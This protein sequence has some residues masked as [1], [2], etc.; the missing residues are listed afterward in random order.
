[1]CVCVCV[2]VS[3][4]QSEY[5]SA[6]NRESVILP[7]WVPPCVNGICA[8]ARAACHARVT[9]GGQHISVYSRHGRWHRSVSLL[10]LCVCE[11]A[12]TSPLSAS[13]RMRRPFP[14]L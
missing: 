2:C 11:D 8:F 7:E 12:G 10:S 13:V 5:R 1:M 9:Q 3:L 4:S 14:L 6:S